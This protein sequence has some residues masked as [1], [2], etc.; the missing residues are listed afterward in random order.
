[1][2]RRIRSPSSRSLL[3]AIFRTARVYASA[4]L[5]TLAF[6]AERP[7]QVVIT[8]SPRES[9]GLARELIRMGLQ[10]VLLP[11][12]SLRPNPEL[13]ADTLAEGIARLDALIALSP[14]SVRFA[15]ALLPAPSLPRGLRLYAIG[16]ASAAAL[17]RWSGR[18]V[19]HGL[20]PTS[21]GLLAA[22][23]L[24]AVQGLKIGLLGAPGGRMLLADTLR[25]RGAE[26]ERIDVYRRELARWDRR[27]Q[28]RLERL[29]QP[30]VL[31][32]SESALAALLVLAGERQHYL[33]A[34]TAVTSSARLARLAAEA[35][36][37][38]VI[39]APG[40]HPADFLAVLRQALRSS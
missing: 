35:R 40:P 7:S 15:R 11:A 21:E 24:S 29:K 16:A 3:I 12:L 18:P 38:R 26:V 36:F 8:R 31:L 34:G 10:P 4:R 30:W 13:R 17:R 9:R 39:Q 28:Q 20:A 5:A 33:L 27:H 22:P 1:M 23:A 25:E 19:E 37:Q 6:V 32:S 14:A 2:C